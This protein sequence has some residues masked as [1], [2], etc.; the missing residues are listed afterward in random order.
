MEPRYRRYAR[1]G[2]KKV[3][4]WLSAL[5]TQMIVT[6]AEAQQACGIQGPA[7]EIGV[8]H[9]R[10]F[11]L[12]HLLTQASEISV[13]FD[14]FELQNES[15][16]RERKARLTANLRAHHGD[17]DRVR[18]VTQDSTQL[19]PNR[20]IELCA[21]RPRLFSI[22]GGR[23][24]AITYHD[25][26]LAHD[27]VCD[28]GV[29][30]LGDY[31]QEAWPEV[32]EGVCRFMQSHHD[33]VPVAIG[34]NKIIFAKST[35]AACA[36]RD[37]LACRFGAQVRMSTAFGHGVVLIRPLTIQLRVARSRIWRTVSNTSLGR[38]LRRLGGR[39]P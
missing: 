19:T 28:G 10:T 3:E 15:T 12:L 8:H 30:V 37:E 35:S 34:G 18:I 5:A 21:G 39:P 31:F 7:C 25:L 16:G 33:L 24:A 22:D 13:A 36:Y 4:G 6:A 2:R 26:V 11:V 1:R 17:L 32:S 27:T 38:A 14:L 23:T 20:V 29:V 9:G